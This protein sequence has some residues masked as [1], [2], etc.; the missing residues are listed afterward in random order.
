M[1]DRQE[2]FKGRAGDFRGEVILHISLVVGDEIRPPEIARLSRLIHFVEA[3]RPAAWIWPTRI[4]SDVAPIK[5]AAVLIHGNT[6]WIATSHHIDF[7]P[8]GGRAGREQ[9]SFRDRVSAVRLGVNAIDFAAQIVR[10]GG[11]FLRVP[12][13]TP[14][15][16]VDGRVTV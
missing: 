13:R 9:V 1:V 15:P 6:E 7:G 16:L 12:W 3:G 8:R 14:G 11:G 2:R 5:T 4:R 10:V